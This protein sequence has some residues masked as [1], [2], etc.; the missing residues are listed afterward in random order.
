M[1][2]RPYAFVQWCQKAKIPEKFVLMSEPD[3][4]FLR[5]I[6]NFM[7]DNVPGEQAYIVHIAAAVAGTFAHNACWLQQ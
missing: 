7:R 1:L 3:H 4:V 5:P 2:N 6:P